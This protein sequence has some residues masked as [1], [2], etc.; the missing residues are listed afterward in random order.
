MNV[1][2]GPRDGQPG[3][4]I[5]AAFLLLLSA[6]GAVCSVQ[7]ANS[8]ATVGAASMAGGDVIARGGG[9][10]LA[11]GDIRTLVQALPETDRKVAGTD[12][13]ALERLVRNEV[14]SRAVLAEARQSGFDKDPGT[15][16]QFSRLHD[17]ALLRLWL[18][19]QAA[20]PADY[21][22]EADVKAA[23]DANQKVLAGPTQYRLA[24]VYIGL[25]DDPAK[26]SAALRKAADV[27]AKLS[28][29]K[30]AADFGRLAEAYSEHADSAGKGG[31]MGFLPDNQLAP[32]VLAAVRGLKPGE[33]AGPVRTT[34]GLHYLKLLDR[35][36]GAA[37]GYAEAHD[38]LA[39]ALRTRRANELSQAYLAG[40]NTRLGISVNQI[41]LAK[42]QEG[43]HQ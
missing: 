33:V 14:V 27:G 39:G 3:G 40:L 32:E 13:A 28:G 1:S 43:M 8:P 36:A 15:Q 6:L 7:A 38:A 34:Q 30:V 22:A 5:V 2:K 17:E 31:D 23:Y 35:K 19:K 11:A 42:L 18:A 26:L 12:V 20:V 25:P 10:T 37:L 29:D 41:A 4:V 16:A 24:Q 9:V 21:P